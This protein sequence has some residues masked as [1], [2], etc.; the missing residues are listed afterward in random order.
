MENAKNPGSI[1]DL[2]HAEYIKQ[3]EYQAASI[4]LERIGAHKSESTVLS[5]GD[6]AKEAYQRVGE[7]F[8]WDDFKNCQDMIMIGCGPLPVT[9]LHVAERCPLIKIYALD[10][11]EKA[12]KVARQVIDVLEVEQIDLIHDD[13]VSYQYGI[14]SIIYIANLVRP[15]SEVLRQIAKTAAPGTLVILRDPTRAGVTVAEAGIDH[16]GSNYKIEGF[17]ED[18][19]VFM[20]KHVYLRL[21]GR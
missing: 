15:K 10:V 19:D 3:S 4:L 14:A 11:D 5:L 16:I 21:V 6:F 1:P 8:E 9:A 7:I 18:N 17:G 20:S 13:G 12:L 2:E